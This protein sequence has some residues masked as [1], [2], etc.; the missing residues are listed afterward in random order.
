MLRPRAALALILWLYVALGLIAVSLARISE[1]SS[2]AQSAGKA[3]PMRR[4]AQLLLAAGVTVGG[5]WLIA[6]VYTPAGLRRFF[7]LFDPLWRLVGPLALTLLLAVAQVLDPLLLW[8][9][10]FVMRIL[11]AP[12]AVRGPVAPSAPRENLANS[13][14]V[15][16]A[17]RPG[18]KS[19]TETVIESSSVRAR[20][21]TTVPAG[22]CSAACS[23]RVPR[24]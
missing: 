11:R 13:F 21:R 1:K 20:M 3:L 8:F 7:H 18:P 10:A 17:G 4:F 2:E 5:A 12:A 15:S 19:S 16:P 22:V 9:E 6:S 23:T 14:S 24:A